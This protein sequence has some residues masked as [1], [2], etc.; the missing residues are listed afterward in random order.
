MKWF[1]APPPP[2]CP[3]PDLRES[4]RHHLPQPRRQR[5]Q[6]ARPDVRVGV[7]VQAL[8]SRRQVQHGRQPLHLVVAPPARPKLEPHC[9][10]ERA[11][12]RVRVQ[13]RHQLAV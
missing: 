13:P 5:P 7:E 2:P 8:R 1:A 4:G 10:A 12:Q 9:A 11:R 3:Q 6:P